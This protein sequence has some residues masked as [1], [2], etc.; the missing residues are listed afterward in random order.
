MYSEKRRVIAG[1]K[2]SLGDIFRIVLER[3]RESG[4]RAVTISHSDTLLP[5]S[6]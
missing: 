3:R 2:N 4:R 5:I 6:W 1:T